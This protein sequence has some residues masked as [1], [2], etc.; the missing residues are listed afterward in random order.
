MMLCCSAPDGMDHRIS[1]LERFALGY[2]QL[3][4][5]RF[6]D[7]F[8]HLFKLGGPHVGTGRVDQI[9]D[10][11]RCTHFGHHRRNCAD[12][13]GQKHARA[14]ACLF[15]A[16]IGVEAIL[17]AHPAEQRLAG[18]ASV[19]PV[20]PLGQEW[21]DFGETPGRQIVDIGDR[22]DDRPAF[23]VVARKD[24]VSIAVRLVAHGRKRGA[25]ARAAAL[26]PVVIA[27]LVDKVDGACILPLVGLDQVG[28]IGHA[29]SA[30][31]PRKLCRFPALELS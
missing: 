26:Q 23:G 12:I 8:G 2:G 30:R 21:R 29:N 28:I 3:A 16:A 19:E 17:T 13:G 1:L 15:L 7:P 11:R 6:G 18:L 31:L 24:G 22:G 27:L 25:F 14:A 10:E 9:A 20:A 4:A 5:M